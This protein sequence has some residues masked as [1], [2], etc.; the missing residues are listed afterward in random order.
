MHTV[1]DE[2]NPSQLT[3]PAILR[4]RAQHSP[5]K[6]AYTFLLDGETKQVQMTYA[7]LNREARR[8]A[9]L[10]LD[11]I[12]IGDRVLMHNA[13][14]IQEGMELSSE[15]RGLFWLPPYHDMGLMGGILQALYTGYPTILMAPT[16]FLQQPLRWLQ[17]LS[18]FHATVS[19]AP[20]F[21]Y[22]LC[23]KKVTP[24]TI[25]TLNLSNWTLA[26][27]GAEPV[28]A[29]TLSCFAET[30]APCGFRPEAFYSC[31]GL[32]ETTLFV[33][34][35][36]RHEKPSI[37]A[38]DGEALEAGHAV[39]ATRDQKGSRLL[40]SCGIGRPGQ[41]VAIV[42]PQALT[43]CAPSTIGEI[44][45]RG[46]NVALGYWGKVEET[47]ETFQAFPRGGDEGPFLRTGDLGFCVDNELFIAGRLKDLIIIRG[48]NLYPQD[49]EQVV[50]KSHPLLR[51]SCCAVFAVEGGQAR[52]TGSEPRTTPTAPTLGERFGTLAPKMQEII[53]W[54]VMHIAQRAQ[55]D[56][57]VVDLHAPFV[58]FGLNSLE[59]IGLSGELGQWLGRSLSPTLIYDYPSQLLLLHNRLGRAVPREL[60]MHVLLWRMHM[61]RLR[62]RSNK[63]SLAC[64]RNF[65]V[66]RALVSMTTSLLWVVILW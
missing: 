47:A 43:P 55:I 16:A 30:F 26:F 37:R 23:I 21:A 20:N 38:F 49:I 5:E 36:Q 65:W 59:A 63:R 19:G 1:V 66:L 29:E 25:K 7:D 28:R 3:L 33:S 64:G 51:Q 56:P 6:E 62:T 57:C 31:Y 9:A 50:E 52:G 17:A 27:T 13:A 35:G 60:P 46:P 45:V 4:W 44:W 42:D 24:E 14:L 10:L 15:D 34:G 53:D 39:E 8:I 2:T 22:D 54:L 12:A 40:V 32:A 18:S 61:L 48:R 41:E 58:Q 11:R